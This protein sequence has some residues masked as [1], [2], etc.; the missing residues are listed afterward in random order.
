[1]QNYKTGI[2][3]F[4]IDIGKSDVDKKIYNKK[5]P[6]YENVHNTKFFVFYKVSL[7]RVYF[8]LKLSY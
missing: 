7:T 8:R 1:M 5:I 6:Y 2:K 3:A 4:A